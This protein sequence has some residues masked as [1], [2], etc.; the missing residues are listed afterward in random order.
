MSN[1][2]AERSYAIIEAVREIADNAY[3]CGNKDAPS[4]VCPSLETIYGFKTLKHLLDS[5]RQ[6]RE[7]VED[8]IVHQGLILE[9]YKV[10]AGLSDPDPVKIFGMVEGRIKHLEAEL[11]SLKD[12][13]P[14]PSYSQEEVDRIT[15]KLQSSLA[16]KEKTITLREEYIRERD[17]IIC[18][19]NDKLAEKEKRV[20][21]LEGEMR[22]AAD[23][24]KRGEWT[25]HSSGTWQILNDALSTPMTGEK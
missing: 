7:V 12:S 25:S 17:R 24:L 11:R 20:A 9:G 18:L 15:K 1:Q 13:I 4:F 22:K 10:L 23:Q 3:R 16:E 2:E 21:V 6:K 5:E 19:K 8:R 14:N